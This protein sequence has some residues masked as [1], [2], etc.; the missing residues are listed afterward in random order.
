[1]GADENV[2]LGVC[3][4]WANEAA[5]KCL[6]S[7]SCNLIPGF[8]NPSSSWI[9]NG[10]YESSVSQQRFR[11]RGRKKQKDILGLLANGIWFTLDLN[12]WQHHVQALCT[13]RYLWAPTLQSTAQPCQSWWF[14]DW[15]QIKPKAWFLKQFPL[16]C[17]SVLQQLWVQM[18]FE[19]K[20]LLL[21]EQDIKNSSSCF[22]A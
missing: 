7:F 17:T 6:H 14:E 22:C 9:R 10:K 11:D 21:R 13:Q 19:S 1:M 8:S 5:T 15:P 20:Q 3:T 12:T 18:A 4:V 2:C 16:L